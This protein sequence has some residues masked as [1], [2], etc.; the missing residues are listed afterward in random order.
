M[1]LQEGVDFYFSAIDKTVAGG[2]PSLL[3][4]AN[5][6]AVEKASGDKGTGNAH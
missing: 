1:G 2:L 3:A 4:F 5:A 6:M